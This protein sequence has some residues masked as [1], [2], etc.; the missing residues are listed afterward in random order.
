[1]AAAGAKYIASLVTHS[2]TFDAA[3]EDALGKSWQ[4]VKQHIFRTR[5]G[6]EAK[7]GGAPTQE[8]KEEVL[9]RELT[10]MLQHD[11]FRKDFAAWV[12]SVRANP[13][14]KNYVD[15]DISEMEGN[16]QIGDASGT[17]QEE[18]YDMKNIAKLKIGKM[19]GN[20]EVGDRTSGED[21]K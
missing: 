14:I 6:L 2:K 13:A 3:K 15:A 16:V 5:P 17:K 21:S 18:A 12:K 20:I 9:T 8:G 4:W 11:D 1:M 10:A 19:K 7:V